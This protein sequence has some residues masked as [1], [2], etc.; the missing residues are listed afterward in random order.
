[1]SPTRMIRSNFLMGEQAIDG[2]K[3]EDVGSTITTCPASRQEGEPEGI[4]RL[5]HFDG[6]AYPDATSALRRQGC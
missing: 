4:D 6:S 1:M 5:R 3:V 2:F